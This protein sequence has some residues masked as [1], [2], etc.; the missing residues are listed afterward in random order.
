MKKE[1]LVPSFCAF[2][3]SGFLTVKVQIFCNILSKRP[4]KEVKKENSSFVRQKNAYLCS[5]IFDDTYEKE[6]IYHND[7]YCHHAGIDDRLHE[8]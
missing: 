6:Q 3:K 1:I 8:A 5:N 7:N 4:K 2:S